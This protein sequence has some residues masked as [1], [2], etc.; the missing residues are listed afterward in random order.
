MAPGAAFK[1]EEK[2][3]ILNTSFSYFGMGIGF[4]RK[5]TIAV[6]GKPP[7]AREFFVKEPVTP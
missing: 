4:S 1:R 2:K 7:T 5:P 6:G 3:A